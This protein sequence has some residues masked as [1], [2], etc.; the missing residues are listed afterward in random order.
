MFYSCL[1]AG[2]NV[3]LGASCN[4]HLLFHLRKYLLKYFHIPVPSNDTKHI[5]YRTDEGG[6]NLLSFCVTDFHK[7]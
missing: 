3:Q 1:P 6:E 2:L 4:T 5:R 7:F